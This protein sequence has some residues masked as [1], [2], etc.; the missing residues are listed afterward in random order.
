M[1]LMFCIIFIPMLCGPVAYLLGK[2]REK[3]L[4]LFAILVTL[5]ELVMVLFAVALQDFTV[6]TLPIRLET[7]GV[8]SVYAVVTAFMWLWT[9]LF[10]KEYF[11]HE[12]EHLGRYQMFMLMTLG[13]TEGVMLSADMMT[14]FVFFEI[15]SFTSFT[16]VIHEQ[17]IEAIRAAYTYLYIA[18]FGGM[19]LFMG[20]SMLRYAAGTMAFDALPAAILT[21]GTQHP[22]LLAASGFCI[23]IG[24]GAKAGMFPL[25]VWLPM[26]HPI[27]PSPAS[28]LL[29]GVLTKVGIYGI[30]MCALFVVPKNVSFGMTVLV[31]GLITMVVGAVMALFSENLKRTLACSSMS[32]I[33]FIL[34]GVAMMVI[35]LAA[36]NQ[37]GFE[38]AFSGTILHMISHSMIKLTLFMAAGV[39]LM[40][41]HALRL[42]EI[43][44]FGREHHLLKISFALGALG[45]SG[46]PMF[47][48]FLSK[49]LL[50]EALT[51]GAA[52]A[53]EGMIPAGAFAPLTGHELSLLMKVFEWIFIIS[54]GLTFAYMLRLFVCIFMAEKPADGMEDALSADSGG[55]I[56]SK[57]VMNPLS[58]FVIFSASVIVFLLGQPPIAGAI[59]GYVTG[60]GHQMTYA[61]SFTIESVIAGVISLAIGTAVYLTVVRAVEKRSDRREAEAKQSGQFQKDTGADQTGARGKKHTAAAGGQKKGI[62][63]VLLQIVTMILTVIDQGL[64][65]PVMLLM[66]GIKNAQKK[67]TH[68][69][70]LYS[71]LSLIFTDKGRRMLSLRGF[72]FALMMTCVGILLILFVLIFKIL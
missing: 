60:S 38:V 3:S 15:L 37:E 21:T 16:W 71:A 56:A 49:T 27:A 10:S 18:V 52:L 70:R 69:T 43:R 39:V 23:L 30:L 64:E 9:E 65:G 12:K 29:S 1:T 42:S 55:S 5:A 7:G 46:V 11:L 26:A 14:A 36:G 58:S 32:Q 4:D 28:A 6:S 19:V 22:Y 44:G 50:H 45:I 51:E 35:C 17:S 20:L 25:H 57:G 61:S 33:G 54:G 62:G 24:F 67:E 2:H 41:L 59:A 40:N 31:L 47:S 63:S 48:G 66:R 68:H 53:A 34:T 72:S 8:H 13:A